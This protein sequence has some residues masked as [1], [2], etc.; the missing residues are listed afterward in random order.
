MFPPVDGMVD[1][2]HVGCDDDLAQNAVQPAWQGN[3]SVIEHGAAIED[4]FEHNNGDGRGTNRQHPNN[5][6]KHREGNFER[7]ETNGRCYIN[8]HVRM[9]HLVQAPQGR[10]LVG[11]EVLQPQC[12]VE[13]DH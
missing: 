6:P 4:D 11:Y 1:A 5:F 7:M 10:P 8:V 3:I 12:E 13:N 2:V 9:V